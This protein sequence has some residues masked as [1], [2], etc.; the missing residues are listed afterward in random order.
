M[1]SLST[2]GGL[3]VVHISTTSSG[4]GAA[5]VAKALQQNQRQRGMDSVLLCGLGEA[6]DH[7]AVRTLGIGRSRHIA[8]VLLQRLTGKEGL[9]NSRAWKRAKQRFVDRA[10]LVHLHNVHGYYLPREVLKAILRKPTVW[11]LQDEWLLSGRCAFPLTCRGFERGCSPC[12]YLGR[13]P[14]AWIDHA[15]REF[16]KRRDLVDQARA[17]FITP[18]ATLRERFLS[19]GF[20]RNRFRVIYNPLDLEPAASRASRLESRRELGLPEDRTVL[21]FVAAETWVARKG[22]DVFDSA[23]R[24]LRDPDMWQ[25]CV[26]G[27]LNRSVRER[28]EQHPVPTRLVG[29]ITDREC[30]RRH[31]LASDVLVTP[32]QGEA[33]PLVAIEAAAMGCRVVCT[34]LP[35]FREIVGREGRYFPTADSRACAE[36]LEDLVSSDEP[37][38]PPL[39]ESESIRR[40][41]CLDRITDSY[42]A[43][44]RSCMEAASSR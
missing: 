5:G 32:S 13:Y 6:T 25:L 3:K 28:F 44:Y 23:A 14:A 9:L 21:L 8:N 11:T 10:D 22:I 36:A 20:P 40:R 42:L 4:G 2:G 15:G 43:A 7:E 33:L 37:I 1:V 19:V 39:A 18:S 16:P 12:P 35:F 41:F 24:R 31:Y 17:L 29:R 26:V 30:L 27:A 38:T 34:D